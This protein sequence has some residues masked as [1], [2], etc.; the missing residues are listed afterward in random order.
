MVEL[1]T[2]HLCVNLRGRD[3]RVAEYLAHALYRHTVVQRHD[4]ERVAA[5]VE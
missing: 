5:D 1:G 2:G 3:V 4:C